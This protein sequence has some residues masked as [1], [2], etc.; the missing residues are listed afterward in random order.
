MAKISYIVPHY[1]RDNILLWHL[2]ELNKQ[3]YADFDVIIVVDGPEDE[4]QLDPRKY[5]FKIR[6]EYFGKKVG[7][8]TT[9]NY[10][11]SLTDAPII[12]FAGSDCIPH[13]NLIMVHEWRHLTSRHSIVQGYT[14]WHPGAVT[15]VTRFVDGGGLQANWNALKNEDGT[16][17]DTSAP[18]FCLTTNFSIDHNLFNNIGGF[19]ESFPGAAWEDVEFGIRLA[20]FNN[21]RT[22]VAPDAIN[23]HYHQYNV[24]SF[25]RRSRMEGYHR[26]KICNVNPEMSWQMMSPETVEASR[27]VHE[28][29][30]M[31]K[32]NIAVYTDDNDFSSMDNRLAIFVEC[33][34]LM[35]A[36]GIADYLDTDAS[37][38]LK[39]YEFALSSHDAISIV[40][41]ADALET[42]H[43]SFAFHCAQWMVIGNSDK[44]YPYAFSAEVNLHSGDYLSARD[45]LKHALVLN[46][47]NEYLSGRFDYVEAKIKGTEGTE[48]TE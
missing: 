3:S 31:K 15:P 16:W 10:G 40:T 29:E 47:D 23:F 41:G 46:Q 32:A 42:G 38:A 30:V 12:M 26:I 43:D 18:S 27:K 37:P 21:L 44:W 24:E 28:S 11:A 1:G 17:V 13:P 2:N 7:P 8:A 35:S 6:L 20:K 48:G 22:V 34:R 33:C 9:R 4:L 39:L 25:L 5:N 36:K 14:P 19:N 45:Y